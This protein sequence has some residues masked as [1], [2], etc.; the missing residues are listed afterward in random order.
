MFD[1]LRQWHQT[2]L[3]QFRTARASKLVGD[4]ELVFLQRRGYVEAGGSGASISRLELSLKSS[5]TGKLLA[6]AG[7]LLKTTRR[8]AAA[9]KSGLSRENAGGAQPL[10]HLSCGRGWE[11]P[12]LPAGSLDAV[13]G[14]KRSD[15]SG[16][17]V[18]SRAVLYR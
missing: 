5:A 7:Q 11:R 15:P 2:Q 9:R 10:C 13:S 3:N 6:A 1:Q 16:N 12:T 4:Q 17:L 8:D 14:A 18:A